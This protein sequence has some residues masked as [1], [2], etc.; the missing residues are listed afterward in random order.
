MDRALLDLALKDISFIDSYKVVQNYW[1]P[2]NGW[3]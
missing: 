3:K 1:D 2:L